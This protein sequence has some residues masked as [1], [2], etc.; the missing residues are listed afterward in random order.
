MFNSCSFSKPQLTDAL[1][2]ETSE[3]NCTT[4][5]KKIVYKLFSDLF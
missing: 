3:Y 1:M 4:A 2:H 5:L